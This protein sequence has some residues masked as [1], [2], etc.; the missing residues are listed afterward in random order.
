VSPRNCKLSGECQSIEKFSKSKAQVIKQE[1]KLRKSKVKIDIN[2][3]RFQNSLIIAV[4][5]FQY[6]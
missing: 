3:P 5:S 6:P 4:E 1:K 2:I